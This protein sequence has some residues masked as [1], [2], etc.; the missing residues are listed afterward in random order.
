M[1]AMKGVDDLMFTYQYSHNIQL[2]ICFTYGGHIQL[3]ITFAQHCLGCNSSITN[4]H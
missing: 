4:I 3:A 2:Y 1:K